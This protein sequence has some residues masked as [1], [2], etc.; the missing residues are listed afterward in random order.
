M[1]ARRMATCT[2]IVV[3]FSGCYVPI[4][5]VKDRTVDRQRAGDSMSPRTRA[6]GA[7]PVASDEDRLVIRDEVIRAEDFWNETREGLLA[8]ARDLRADEYQKLVV[9]QSFRWINDKIADVLLY[10]RAALRIDPQMEKRVD[11][12]V[13]RDMR[14]VV[15]TE[16]DGVQRKFERHLESRGSSLVEERERRRRQLVIAAF[17]ETEIRPKIAKPT[18]AELVTA[19]EANQE[20]WSKPARRR[21]SLIDIR[22]SEYL[23][24]ETDNPTREESRRAREKAREVAHTV[25]SE[26]DRGVPFAELARKYSHG[27]HAEEGGAWGWVRLEGVRDRF[28]PAVQRLDTLQQGRVSQPIK[29]S[30]GFFLVRCDELDPGFNPTFES[31][32]PRLDD[33]HFQAEYNRLMAEL[34]FKLRNEV[35]LDSRTLEQFHVTT[36]DRALKKTTDSAGRKG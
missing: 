31:V 29:T 11:R 1:R 25:R 9:E 22:V 6:R 15:T 20:D 13:D 18:R 17:L 4:G 12:F 19:F 8:R 3:W 10:H 21:M 23:P 27:L 7:A 26:L 30:D 2:L 28:K 35:G 36:V 34:V 32:Q 33:R 16:F 14:L 5:T 24:K